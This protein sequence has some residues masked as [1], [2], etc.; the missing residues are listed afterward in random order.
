V[1]TGRRLPTQLADRRHHQRCLALAGPMP[2]ALAASF[3]NGELA[4]LKII[5]DEVR[6]RGYCSLSKREISRRAQVVRTIVCRA[7]RAA[8]YLGL[9]KVDVRPRPGRKNLTSVITI[10]GHEWGVWLFKRP[11]RSEFERRRLSSAEDGFDLQQQQGARACARKPVE[12]YKKEE[13]G[14]PNIESSSDM[15]RQATHG[16]SVAGRPGSTRGFNPP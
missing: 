1:P 9:I 2:P 6:E 10:I 8:I 14:L 4:A 15:N 3:T 12:I 13:R 5:G 7:Q 16:Q 11:S